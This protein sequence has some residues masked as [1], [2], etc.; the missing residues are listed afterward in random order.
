MLPLIMLCHFLGDFVCQSDWMA[1]GKST[2]L[3]P[4]L[5]HI[6]VYS[7]FLLPFGLKYALVNGLAHLIIDYNT[8]RL[9]SRM[10][11]EQRVHVFFVVIGLDQLLHFYTLYYTLQYLK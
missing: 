1:K 3:K 8:S 6:L 4:L 5:V 7:L 9:S 2:N 11:K 10:W